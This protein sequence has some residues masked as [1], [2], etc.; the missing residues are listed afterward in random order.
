MD[1]FE[2]Y[3]KFVATEESA[4]E[5]TFEEMFDESKEGS[6]EGSKEASINYEQM[7]SD[8]RKDLDLKTKEC[9]EL[10]ARIRDEP[11]DDSKLTEVKETGNEE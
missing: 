11:I 10:K 6:K 2:A 9:D 1:V 4:E 3:E 7:I 5:Q 8:L